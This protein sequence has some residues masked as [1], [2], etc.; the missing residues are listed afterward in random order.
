MLDAPPAYWFRVYRSF[1]QRR[2]DRN[3]MKNQGMGLLIP[4]TTTEPQGTVGEL[5]F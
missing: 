2:K 4:F 3:F 1:V 5:R